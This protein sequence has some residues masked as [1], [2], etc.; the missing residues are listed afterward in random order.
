M[1][2]FDQKLIERRE[3]LQRGGYAAYCLFCKTGRETALAKELNDIYPSCVAL[4]FLRTM[5]RSRDGERFE[6][7][8]VL[9]KGYIFL[10]LP[11][12]CDAASIRSAQT[13]FRILEDV[14]GIRALDGDNRRYA[15]WVLS[16]GGIVGISKALR[17]GSRVKIIDGPLLQVEGY[18]AEY[19]KKNRNCRIRIDLGGVEL[20]AWLPFAWVESADGIVGK[21]EEGTAACM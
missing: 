2:E 13:G 7:Q 17:V 4:P 1:W 6:E 3:S 15:E 12:A 5:H 20:K 9:L 21:Y 16:L 11:K 19:S 18:I 8:D 10:Y 14:D